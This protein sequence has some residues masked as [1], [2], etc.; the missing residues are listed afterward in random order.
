MS[1]I[2]LDQ[3]DNDSNSI[4]SHANVLDNYDLKN[5]N[6]TKGIQINQCALNGTQNFSIWEF[7]G[8]EPYKIFF[9]HFIGDQNCIHI[10]VYNLNQS[11]KNCFNECVSWLEYL[12][13]R[14]GLGNNYNS[15]NTHVE[16][17]NHLSSMQVSFN[18]LYSAPSS[19]THSQQYIS[20]CDYISNKS[21]P[22]DYKTTSHSSMGS[23]QVIFIG[24]HADLDKSC[25][26]NEADGQFTSE[27]AMKLRELLKNYY[28]ND[29]LFDLNEKHF[30][31]DARAAWVADIKKLIEHLINLKQKVCEKLPRCTMLL[32]RT[33][34]H[35][36]NWRKELVS[37]SALSNSKAQM[38][39]ST[40]S[41]LPTFSSTKYPI[42]S[43][44]HFNERIRE[45]INPLASDEHLKELLQQLQLMGEIVFLEYSC[46][47]DMDR[48]IC[49]QPEWLCGKVLG[50]LFSYE[51][52]SNVNPKNLHGI[53]SLHDLSKIFE[54]IC[55]NT[56]LLKDIFI[57]LDLCIELD[58]ETTGEPVYE[59]A[60]LNFLSEPMPLAFQTIKNVVSNSKSNNCL[61]Q[62]S[63][64][65][66]NGFHL[67]TS[68]FH[69]NMKQV[70]SNLMPTSLI[71]SSINCSAIS[72]SVSQ[73]ASLFF[74]IQVNLRYLTKNFYGELIED[75]PLIEQQSQNVLIAG[76]EKFSSK[77]F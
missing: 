40:H 29:D 56:R 42:I 33:L 66:F 71:S 46:I 41:T 48:M 15:L 76:Q 9:D 62:P 51:R 52:Y 34:F 49:F 68:A 24:T 14:I 20:K 5:T 19:P 74:R 55:T 60:S 28:I 54:Q 4:Y 8:Y 26:R 65:V 59:F 30:V 64:F 45:F 44:K 53:Y 16:N 23:M 70:N 58:N 77:F 7:S 18:S 22:N 50:H 3:S 12:R 61:S 36:Q 75:S 63:L 72:Y 37:Q 17:I 38:N 67:K 43:L 11:Q 35:L 25:S 1:S 32:N 2:D 39:V 69:L 10:I 21:H 13:S 27:K 31:L 57:A 47:N 73:L 6:Y